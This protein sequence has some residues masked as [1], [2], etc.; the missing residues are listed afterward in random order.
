[1]LDALELPAEFQ[2]ATE[3]DMKVYYQ[4]MDVDTINNTDIFGEGSLK[5]QAKVMADH[6]KRLKKVGRGFAKKTFN[7]TEFVSARH[8][9]EDETL[10]SMGDK[11]DS[12]DVHVGLISIGSDPELNGDDIS[13]W[14]SGS[15]HFTT[16]TMC[17]Q[18]PTEE[19]FR[20]EEHGSEGEDSL[21][22]RS[23]RNQSIIAFTHQT[24][25]TEKEA[26]SALPRRSQRFVLFILGEGE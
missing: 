6:K 25:T 24:G 19:S 23:S 11:C 13:D 20:P 3:N 22:G 21:S 12:T 7:S 16:S 14:E 26:S 4:S 2:R 18:P 10:I 8:L 17:A 5:V 15:K 9:L 1:M